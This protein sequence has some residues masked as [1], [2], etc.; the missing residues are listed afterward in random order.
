MSVVVIDRKGMNLSNCL[1]DLRVAEQKD[2]RGEE[3][4]KV[5]EAV[6]DKHIL[7]DRVLEGDLGDDQ[8]GEVG[9]QAEDGEKRE[10]QQVLAS[11]QCEVW[12]KIHQNM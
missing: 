1:E 3:M 2:T 5:A 10:A 9:G 12:S 6:F 4:V 7:K 8:V 11:P